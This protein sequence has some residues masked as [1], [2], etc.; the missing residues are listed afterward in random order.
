MKCLKFAVLASVRVA[1]H[2]EVPAERH[3][4]ATAGLKNFSPARHPF[5]Q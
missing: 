1:A 4:E 2:T 5:C 3:V